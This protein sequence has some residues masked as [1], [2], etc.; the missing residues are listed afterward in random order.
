[1]DNLEGMTW[2]PP[3]PGGGRSLVLVSDDNFNPAQSTQFIAA[4]YIPT[5]PER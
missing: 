1:M 3:L 2:G 4:E 5:P